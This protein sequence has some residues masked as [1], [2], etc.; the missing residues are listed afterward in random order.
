MRGDGAAMISRRLIVFAAPLALSGCGSL[1]SSQPYIARTDWP[2]APKPPDIAAHGSGHGVVLVRSVLAGP[3]LDQTGLI[4]LQPDGSMHRGYYNRWAVPPAEALTAALIAWLQASGDFKAVVGEG[5][6]LTPNLIVETTLDTLL[7]DPPRH[8]AR[9]AMTLVVA[10][11]AGLGE[12]PVVQRRLVAIEPLAGAT[13]STLVAAQRA[14][15][16]SLMEQA[17]ALIRSAQG[18]E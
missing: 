15:V 9:S 7:A 18:R 17:L 6:A 2:L 4:T 13:A 1:I 14:A 8:E 3:G 11:P 10:K 16:V 5:T 12:I